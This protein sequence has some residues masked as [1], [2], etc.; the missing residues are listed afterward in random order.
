MGTVTVV[1]VIA[2]VILAAVAGIFIG[3]RRSGSAPAPSEPP[4]DRLAAPVLE[5][6]VEGDEARVVFG[7]PL[8]DGELDPVL[9]EMLTREA[10][11]VIRDKRHQLPITEAHRVVAFA[12]RDG[13]TVRVGTIE[14]ETPGVLPPPVRPEL[15]PKH[16]PG[17][18]PFEMLSDLQH[19]P[20]LASRT[21]SEDLAP[22][23][24]EIRLAANVE[25]GLRSQGIDPVTAGA[26]DLVLGIMRLTGHAITTRKE[27]TYRAERAGIA[28]FVRVVPHRSGDHPELGDDEI[29]RFAV[30]FV[31]SG[32]DR[33]V[34][35]TEKYS[36]FE[37]Y[38]RER[39]DPR[40]RFVTRERIQHFVDAL[41]LR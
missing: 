2:V 8:P 28:T 25:I 32:A 35:V 41:A 3:L 26:G 22:L 19:P 40:V 34:L 13:E 27:N 16:A 23:G 21:R 37:I 6:H 18:D 39:R 15:L 14:L 11:E 10:V 5:F 9:V 36:P 33:G 24:E 30:D 12:Q 17:F 1:V 29:R 7:V 31:E 20:G 38:E 4:S